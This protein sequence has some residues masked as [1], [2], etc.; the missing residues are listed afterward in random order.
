MKKAL[1]TLIAGL[2]V[3]ATA[4]AEISKEIFSCAYYGGCVHAVLRVTGID[5][6]LENIQANKNAQK[7]LAATDDALFFKQH[8]VSAQGG[9]LAMD[10]YKTVVIKVSA[11]DKL[12]EMQ[13]VDHGSYSVYEDV[14]L[15]VDASQPVVLEGNRALRIKINGRSL[16]SKDL[17]LAHQ[18]TQNLIFSDKLSVKNGNKTAYQ[19]ATDAVVLN[20]LDI[21]F[22]EFKSRK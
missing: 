4:H 10:I 2:M 5:R 11:D 13:M 3:Q 9:E 22:A 15:T 7:I 21:M 12:T 17:Q 16:I 6:I 8:V 20:E 14:A 18:A 1:L 19:S